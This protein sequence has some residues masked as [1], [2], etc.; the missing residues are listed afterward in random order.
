MTFKTSSSKCLGLAIE[1]A[2]LNGL[3]TSLPEKN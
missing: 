1:N 3:N 2:D